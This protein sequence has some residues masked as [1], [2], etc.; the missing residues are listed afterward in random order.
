VGGQ[1]ILEHGLGAAIVLY[2]VVHG[3][4]PTQNQICPF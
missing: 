1:L 4:Q 2:G 3:H